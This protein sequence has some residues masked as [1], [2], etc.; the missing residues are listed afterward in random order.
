MT[1][2][3]WRTPAALNISLYP[4]IAVEQTTKKEFSMFFKYEMS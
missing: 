3:I 4:E 2:A 1:S